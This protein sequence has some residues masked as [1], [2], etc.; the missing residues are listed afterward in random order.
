MEENKEIRRILK[1][2]I[3]NEKQKF[4]LIYGILLR[5]LVLIFFFSVAIAVIYGDTESSL[6]DFWV[7]LGFKVMIGIIIGY[8]TGLIEWN[9]YSS[10]VEKDLDKK[11]YRGV[12]VLD[13]IIGWGLV[14]LVITSNKIIDIV[15]LIVSLI[16][17]GIFGV[18]F[19]LIIW[20]TMDFD[21]VRSIGRE[22]KNKI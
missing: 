8:I 16:V 13:G 22:M 20:Y 21:K 3:K 7:L 10:I 6:H 15:S 11:S 9:F 19:G 18:I 5:S 4:I 17:W 1:Y 14:C 2:V 12:A